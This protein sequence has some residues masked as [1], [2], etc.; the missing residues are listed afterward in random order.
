MKKNNHDIRIHVFSNSV[1]IEGNEGIREELAA[2]IRGVY[3]LDFTLHE[4]PTMHFT[5]HYQAIR[6]DIFRVKQKFNPHVVYTTSPNAL[7]PDHRVVG[8]AVE[9]I[10]LE[11]T[12]YAMEGI[13]DGHNQHINKWV[14]VSLDDMLVKRVALEKYQS[15]KVRGYHDPE[16]MESWARFRG[17]QIGKKYAEGFQVLRE[18]S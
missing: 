3:D 6:D 4:Y 18:V 7:H 15:Q 16:L 11:T 2:S 5:E 13:R 10:F 1:A 8:E 17:G 14:E 12:V 9:S